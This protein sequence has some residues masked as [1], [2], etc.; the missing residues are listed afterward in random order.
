VTHGYNQKPTAVNNV[1]TLASVPHIARHGAEWYRGL[2][3]GD[4]AGT[5]I[6]SLSGDIQ[7]PGNYEVPLGLPL[8]TLLNDWA[9]GAPD[10]RTIQAV[11]MAGLSG[12]FLA[13]DDLDVTLDEPSIRSKGSFLGAGGVIVFDDSRDMVKA[14]HDAMEFFAD[15]SCGKCFPCR[16]GTQRLTERLA[17]A[18]GPADLDDW[19]TEVGDIGETMRATSACGLGMAAPLVTDSLIKYFPDKVEKHVR[20]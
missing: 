20:K 5:K 17:G 4:E 9:A 1:E 2:G 13:G 3:L 18:A 8:Q 14:A 19:K 16:I 11:T 7:R 6:I 15:E 12:G 10:G